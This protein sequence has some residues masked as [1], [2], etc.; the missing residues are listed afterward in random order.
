MNLYNCINNNVTLS[1]VFISVKGLRR[2]L[3]VQPDLKN[4]I[5]A[6]IDAIEDNSL[7]IELS[8]ERKH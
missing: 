1:I 7:R 3:S 8:A 2:M 5:E 6:D 4:Y